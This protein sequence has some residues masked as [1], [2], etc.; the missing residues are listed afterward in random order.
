MAILTI[1]LQKD[2][3]QR[4]MV[5]WIPMHAKDTQQ[6]VLVLDAGDELTV[7]VEGKEVAKQDM[8]GV[9]WLA[10][11]PEKEA[12]DVPNHLAWLRGWVDA[13]N[14]SDESRRVCAI[15]QAAQCFWDWLSEQLMQEGE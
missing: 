9:V 6:V 4:I 15:N 2:S 14:A 8:T 3:A 7:S 1:D 5:N 13:Y 12:N 10:M 11:K